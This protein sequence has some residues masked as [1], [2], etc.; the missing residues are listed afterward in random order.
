MPIEAYKI[1]CEIYSL[2]LRGRTT[3]NTS[4]L[5]VTKPAGN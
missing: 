2:R 1:A 4:E 3:G 5:V